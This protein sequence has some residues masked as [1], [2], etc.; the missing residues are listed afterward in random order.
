MNLLKEIQRLG[1]DTEDGLRRFMNHSVLYEKM[2][3]K[4]PASLRNLTLSS[5]LQCR[6]IPEALE[7]AHNIKGMTGNLSLTPLYT[8]YSNI[9]IHLRADRLEEAVRIYQE[10]LPLQEEFLSCIES[11]HPL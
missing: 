1:A 10:I 5:H 8:A 2:L 6:R 7:A 3:M 11:H 9:V 4:F